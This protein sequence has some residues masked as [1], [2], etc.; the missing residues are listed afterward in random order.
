[1]ATTWHLTNGGQSG[2]MVVLERATWPAFFD[3]PWR[4][5]QASMTQRS[6]TM[7]RMKKHERI[8]DGNYTGEGK[9][10]GVTQRVDPD[11]GAVVAKQ[12]TISGTD[13][14]YNFTVPCPSEE[15]CADLLNGTLAEFECGEDYGT[16]DGAFIYGLFLDGFDLKMRRKAPEYAALL[17]EPPKMSAEERAAKSAAKKA[18][19]T[20]KNA[21][22]DLLKAAGIESLDDLQAFLDS[23]TG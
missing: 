23:Q 3:K 12:Q 4:N 19:N 16:I 17:L 15:E 7:A 20:R 6:L 5:G 22:D 18:E 14:V 2:K 9:V 11:T 1:M 10:S 21:Q 8:V 13:E